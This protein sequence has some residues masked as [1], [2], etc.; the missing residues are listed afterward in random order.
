MEMRLNEAERLIVERKRKK[1]S[2]GELARQIGSYQT[3][4]S[5]FENAQNEPTEQE[6]QQIEQVL[7]AS[8]WSAAIR[9]S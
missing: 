4:I 8:I 6:K 1:L 3:R 5:R 2:Q 7:D 9:S